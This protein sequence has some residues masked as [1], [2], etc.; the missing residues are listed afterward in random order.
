MSRAL[1]AAPSRA[2]LSRYP[3]LLL[4]LLALPALARAGQDASSSWT[5][6]LQINGMVSTSLSH[7]FNRPDS[8]RTNQYRVFDQSDGSFQIDAVELVFQ[9]SPLAPGEGGFRFDLTAGSSIPRVTASAGLFRNP[10]GDAQDV[11]IHQAMVSYILPVGRG[12]RLDFGKQITHTGYEVIEGYDGLNDHA[13]R[14]ILFGYAIPFTHTGLRAGY[15]FSSKSA[16]TVYIVNGWDTVRDNN[17]AKSFGAQFSWSPGSGASLTANYLGGAEQTDNTSNLRHLIDLAGVWKPV[18]R[19]SCGVNLDYGTE[20]HVAGSAGTAIW[21][22][23]AAY[24]RISLGGPLSVA[25]RGEVF[26][27]RAGS[28][29]GIRQTLREFT[30]TPTLTMKGGLLFRADLRSDH[31]NKMVFEK[32]GAPG[33]SK[34]QNTI[35]LNAI[36]TF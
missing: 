23:A 36:Y 32:K 5:E 33:S 31:S 16:G 2:A 21:R 19:A 11:D 7:N 1:L 13:T 9:R 29:T 15:P 17:R 14:S 28:R 18:D 8:T 35:M 10:Q 3:F 25:V 24:T 26:E 34:N 27:D 30:L 4:A 6:S 22:G 12:L 20:E